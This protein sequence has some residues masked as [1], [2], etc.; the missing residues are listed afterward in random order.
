ME[1]TAFPYTVRRSARRSIALAVD[2]NGTVRVSAPLFAPR[3][4]I[5]RV[6]QKHWPWVL[7]KQAQAT[8]AQTAHPAPLYQDGDSFPVWGIPV[9]LAIHRQVPRKKAACARMDQALCVFLPVSSARKIPAVKDL[10]R[11]W[12]RQETERQISEQLPALAARMGVAYRTIKVAHQ[13]SRWGSCS[14]QGHL[15]FNGRLALFTPA[16]LEYVMVHELA[17]LKES[18]HSTRFWRVVESLLPDFK[19][20]RKLL[21]HTAVNHWIHTL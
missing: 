5:E 15:R 19:A 3:F 17:H 13:K 7:R 18:N 8:R 6:V 9:T 20:R 16:A 12:F 10:L 2:A 11:E 1:L 14:R 21:S 4:W